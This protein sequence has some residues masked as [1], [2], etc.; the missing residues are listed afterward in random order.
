[1]LAKEC[2]SS[3]LGLDDE[4]SFISETTANISV[5]FD[6]DTFMLATKVYQRAGKSHLKQA[7]R[8]GHRDRDRDTKASSTE[9]PAAKTKIS[10]V[11][12]LAEQL[13]KDNAVGAKQNFLFPSL[14]GDTFQQEIRPR[15][16]SRLMDWWKDSSQRRDITVLSTIPSRVA[17]GF[18]PP[19]YQPKKVLV[20]GT[21]ESGK[22]TL[23]QALCL[24][25]IYEGGYS[26]ETR[27]LFSETIWSNVVQSTRVVLTVMKDLELK[28]E[29]P[30]RNESHAQTIFMLP[31]RY[32]GS[33]PPPEAFQAINSLWRDDGFQA[34][35]RR[36][37]EYQL[38]DNFDHFATSLERIMSPDYIPTDEDIS[39]SRT[40]TT[41]IAETKLLHHTIEYSIFDVGGTRSERE[42]RW[43]QVFDNVDVIVF[44]IDV[45]SYANVL[46]EHE[47]TNCMREQMTLFYYIVNSRWF[48][49]SHFLVVF[50]KMDCLEDCLRTHD[51]D[52]YFRG[53]AQDASI[54]PVESY[55][56]YI[57]SRFMNL[58]KSDMIRE[59]IKMIRADLVHDIRTQG[60]EIWDTLDDMVRSEDG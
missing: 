59:K 25:N 47:S 29:N 36:R 49:N 21:S 5:N 22:S 57:E 42:K 10:R 40:R 3:V 12:S 23:L 26:K 34:A 6:F 46:V 27:S 7:I 20:L 31:P 24:S 19:E 52:H 55:M 44:T 2:S 32:L 39:R 51:V 9:S 58:I 45:R 54:G 15:N 37:Y 48:T 1:M 56:Q 38:N 60:L 4:R 16:S 43:I 30:G 18:G 8:A 13:K 11:V 17:V 41:G 14:S 33:S 28:L 50:T 35:F 53:Y